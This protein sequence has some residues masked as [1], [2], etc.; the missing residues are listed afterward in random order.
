MGESAVTAWLQGIWRYPVKGFTPEALTSV[1]LAAGRALPFDRVYAVE[2]GPSGFDPAAPQHISKQKF[3][4]LANIPAVAQ[5]RTR[6]DDQAGR[7]HA[8]APGQPDFAGD[9]DSELGAQAFAA[10]LG[11]GLGDAARGPLRLLRAPAGHRFMDDEEGFVSIINLA[12]LRALERTLGV[13]VDPLRLRGNF[14]IDGWPA[15]AED[16]LTDQ[17]I[18]IGGARLKGI[19]TITR[20]VATHVNPTTGARDLELVRG[21]FQAFGHTHCGLYAAV[22]DGGQVTRGDRVTTGA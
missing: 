11:E 6:L 18:T 3:T 13:E 16:A 20:C 10:W 9:L 15:W 14:Y 4:V 8:T 12:S 22:Q 19:K 7:L 2:D 17:L 5:V 21:L 1:T